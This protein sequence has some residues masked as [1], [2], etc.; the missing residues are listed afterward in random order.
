MSYAK[1]IKNLEKYG[2]LDGWCKNAQIE[3][4]C[5]ECGIV[6]QVKNHGQHWIFTTP[7]L[8]VQWWP[9]TG[10]MIR[11]FQ[12]KTPRVVN[13]PTAVIAALRKMLPTRDTKVRPA[14]LD[15]LDELLM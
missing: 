10:K 5:H 7:G 8:N 3:D 2:N 13:S 14:Y 4:L 6:L 11:D 12:W 9:S 15:R 1:R